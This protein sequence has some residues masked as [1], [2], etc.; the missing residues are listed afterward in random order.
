MDVVADAG[1]VARRVILPED[2]DA[3]A[4]SQRH[5]Q[6]QGDQVRFRFMRFAISFDGAGHVEVAQAGVAKPVNAV[7]P[8][9]HVLHQ[10][11][12]L[13]VRVGRLKLRIF[14]DR[15]TDRLT[16]ARRRRAE[17]QAVVPGGQ[18]GLQQRERSRGV[19]A[20]INLR[21]L[22][23][24]ARL[25]QRG[26]VHHALETPGAECLLQQRTVGQVA[27]N[28][29]GPRSHRRPPAVT[30]IVK[31]GHGMS[32]GQQNPCHGAADVTGAACYQ[33]GH[34]LSTGTLFPTTKV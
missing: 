17:H 12:A 25:D 3:L 1:A 29:L 26:K 31:D 34:R 8:A 18:H 6:D 10:Q 19:I 27:L 32:A 20:K 21:S 11:L 5:V 2:L 14:Q 16:V 30:Q 13:A 24:F 7:E 28:K 15:R 33:D 9:Q 23:A 22:H 4:P